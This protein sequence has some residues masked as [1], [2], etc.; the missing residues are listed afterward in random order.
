MSLTVSTV[1]VTATVT[2]TMTVT[3]TVTMTVTVTVTVSLFICYRL[4]FS[5]KDSFFLQKIYRVASRVFLFLTSPSFVSFYTQLRLILFIY[6]SSLLLFDKLLINLQERRQA[7]LPRQDFT[8]AQNMT[9]TQ[10]IPRQKTPNS[11]ARAKHTSRS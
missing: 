11:N 3:V 5:K 1:T 9:I 7:R 2:M 8:H 4:W 10:H 6:W